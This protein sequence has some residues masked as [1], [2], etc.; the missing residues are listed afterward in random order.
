MFISAF[1]HKWFVLKSSTAFILCP[2]LNYF[3][4]VSQFQVFPQKRIIL[5]CH[6]IHLRSLKSPWLVFSILLLQIHIPS[7]VAPTTLLV[8]PSSFDFFLL[9]FA[10]CHYTSFQINYHS[11]ILHI[12]FLTVGNLFFSFDKLIDGLFKWNF[13]YYSF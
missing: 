3:N 12:Y 2:S 4:L 9:N 6:H 8:F 10:V 13:V 1:P 11:T 7:T 5:V